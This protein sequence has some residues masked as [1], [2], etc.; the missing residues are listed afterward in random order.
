MEDSLKKRYAYKLLTNLVSLPIAVITQAIIPRILGPM[1]YGNYSFLTGFYGSL[2]GFFDSGTSIALFTKL[3]QRQKEKALVSFYWQF[4]ALVLIL[5]LSVI[6]VFVL[7]GIDRMIWPKQTVRFIFMGLFWGWLKWL[8][9]VVQKILDALGYTRQGEIIR[10]FQ[11]SVACVLLVQLY[12]VGNLSLECFFYY[13]YGVVLVYIV[14]CYLYLQYNDISL[15]PFVKVNHVAYVKEFYSYSGPL[16][17]ASSIALIVNV[18]DR[19]LLQRF[20]GS[21]EQGYFGL[22][23]QAAAVCFLF[24]SAM[25]PIFTREFAIAHE[26]AELRKKRY[27][28]MKYVPLLYFVSAFLA[29]F[30]T[31]NASIFVRL[32]GGDN[33]E[34]AVLVLAI[35]AFYPIHQTYGQLCGAVFYSTNATKQYRNIRLFNM[36]ISLPISYVLIAPVEFYGLGFAA[37]GLAVKMIATQLI[38]VNV[39]LYFVCKMIRLKFV[40]FLLQQILVIGLLLVLVVVTNYLCSLLVTHELVRLLLSGFFYLCF[41]LILVFLYPKII[42]FRRNDLINFI[43]SVK[44]RII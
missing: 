17:F 24:S 19:W 25:T 37:Q 12:Y 34:G 30:V 33:Y 15:F 16:V 44:E 31:F 27:L 38:G 21:E 2:V 11:K 40:K 39:M 22:A 8:F 20:F 43:V 23:Y 3:S 13:E 1:N 41:S 4:V 42:S 36:A 9:Q 28:F 14:S 35:M 32:L 29:L 6:S 5:M 26:K 18:F 10:M 7:I